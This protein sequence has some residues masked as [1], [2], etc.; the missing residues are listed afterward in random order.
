MNYVPSGTYIPIPPFASDVYGAQLVRQAIPTSPLNNAA[1]TL[2]EFIQPGGIPK[3]YTKQI[4]SSPGLIKPIIPFGS[5]KGYKKYL[6]D[7]KLGAKRSGDFALNYQFGYA[8]IASD[9]VGAVGAINMGAKYIEQLKRDSGKTVRRQ[10]HAATVATY[11]DPVHMAGSVSL[12]S[13]GHNI[14]ADRAS[15]Y[16]SSADA[17]GSVSM[18]ESTSQKIW[19][20]GGFRFHFETPMSYDKGLESVLKQVDKLSGLGLTAERLYQ[21]TPFTWLVDWNCSLGDVISNAQ[22]FSEDGLIMLYGYVMRTSVTIRTYTLSGI[23]FRQFDPGPITTTY[24]SVRKERFRGD[25]FGFGSNP[26][27]YNSRQW[28]LLSAVGMTQGTGT[29]IRGR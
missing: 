12:T 11:N 29:T 18:T 3:A 4:L 25:P 28:G 7:L 21:L 9:V 13:L 23:K 22:R 15:L 6:A 19:F 24:R 14:S 20:S 10:R 5:K 16:R 17:V 2:G 1:V 8:P 27:T 26:Q